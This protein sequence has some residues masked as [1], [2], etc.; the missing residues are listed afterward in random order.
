MDKP[1]FSVMVKIFSSASVS[2]INYVKRD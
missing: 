2:C 1:F